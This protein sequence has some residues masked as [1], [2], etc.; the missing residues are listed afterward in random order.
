MGSRR[1]CLCASATRPGHAPPRRLSQ[2]WNKALI[3]DSLNKLCKINTC[4][5][6]LCGQ[7][8]LECR[9]V[10]WALLHP[11]QTCL[12]RLEETRQTLPFGCGP[13]HGQHLER[14]IRDPQQA[15]SFI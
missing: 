13:C 1:T 10:L 3:Q 2:G 5:S 15:P 14:V 11:H 8:E 12:T 4:R 7:P 6:V 9:R